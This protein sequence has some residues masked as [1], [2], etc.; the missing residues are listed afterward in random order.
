MFDTCAMHSSTPYVFASSLVLPGKV[1]VGALC[2]ASPLG[3][4]MVVGHVCR[5]C[6][7]RLAGHELMTNLVVLDMVGYDII[8]GMDWLDAHHAMVD[9]YRKRVIVHAIDGTVLQFCGSVG[10]TLAPM[11]AR[12]ISCLG[13]LGDFL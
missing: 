12:R 4:E 9:C 13:V 8:L 6:I 7:V 1:V 5:S 2:V 11:G 10:A 3:G